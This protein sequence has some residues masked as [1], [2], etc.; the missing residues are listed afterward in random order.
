MSDCCP[1]ASAPIVTIDA[2]STLRDLT[3]PSIGSAAPVACTLDANSLA[4]RKVRWTRFVRA[5]AIDQ[6][7]GSGVLRV[8]FRPGDAT[9]AELRELV[10]LEQGCCAHLRWGVTERQE[11]VYLTVVG[12]ESDLDGL[13]VLATLPESPGRS[14]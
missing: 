5:A 10:V 8:R 2:A 13:G 1:P 7:R 14:G 9:S 6:E 12:D 3:P 11:G 4:D